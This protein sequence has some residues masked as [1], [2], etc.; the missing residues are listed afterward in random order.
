MRRWGAASM[1]CHECHMCGRILVRER[2]V[3]RP[4]HG[5]CPTYL[6]QRKCPGL[7][8]LQLACR[9]MGSLPQVLMHACTAHGAHLQWSPKRSVMP[10]HTAFVHEF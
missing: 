2:P 7:L 4:E 9:V 3:K 1:V 6:Q 5:F 10:K 8:A